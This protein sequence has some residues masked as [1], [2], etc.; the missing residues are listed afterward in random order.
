[1]I[2]S[3]P[4]KWGSQPDDLVKLKQPGGSEKILEAMLSRGAAGPASSL[5]TATASATLAESDI[6][7]D[8]E[9]GVYY[10]KRPETGRRCFLKW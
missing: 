10:K 5:A 3:Q 6:A 1:M 2:Q 7:P 8:I 4:G 9:I